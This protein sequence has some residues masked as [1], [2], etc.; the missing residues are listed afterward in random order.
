MGCPFNGCG[1]SNE[2]PNLSL[3]LA[4][5]RVQASR[6]IG[7]ARAIASQTSVDNS[8]EFGG[9]SVGY[10]CKSGEVLIREPAGGIVRAQGNSNGAMPS[11]V[12]ASRPLGSSRAIADW[13]PG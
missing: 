6:S 8:R 12:S 2:C 13:M 9:S 5:N 11:R 4:Q 3:C 7:H 10:D 1:D